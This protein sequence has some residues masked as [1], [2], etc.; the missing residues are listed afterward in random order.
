VDGLVYWLVGGLRGHGVLTVEVVVAVEVVT[1]VVAVVAAV[2][3]V[4]AVVGVVL[5]VVIVTVTV[6][7]G[8]RG[9]VPCVCGSRC[10]EDACGDE[11][12]CGRDATCAD[13]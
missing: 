12:G 4:S 9:V 7:I 1:A 5:A 10:A 8:T 11:C 2:A 13:H 3:V 6:T